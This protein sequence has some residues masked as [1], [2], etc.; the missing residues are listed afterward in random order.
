MS[1]SDS[2]CWH[3]QQAKKVQYYNTT[4]RILAAI[5]EKGKIG[6]FNDSITIYH[7]TIFSAF[8][9]TWYGD[10]K[11]KGIAF[12]NNFFQKLA[13]F[14]GMTINMG[15]EAQTVEM[16]K[17]LESILDLLEQARVGIINLKDTYSQY[18]ETRA[19]LDFVITDRIN[20]VRS[21]AR[22]A[23]NAFGA[24]NTPII[25]LNSPKNAA[26]N[27]NFQRS[28]NSGQTC[29]GITSMPILSLDMGQN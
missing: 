17:F 29:P 23:L 16:R 26:V 13:Q 5:P 2:D 21:Q 19:A 9:R 22:E 14:I 28:V 25:I 10:N 15:E 7:N 24:N 20:C 6:T 18:P 4:L 8:S 27:G 11:D 12:L 3:T 1:I